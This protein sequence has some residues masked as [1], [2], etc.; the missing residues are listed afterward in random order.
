MMK[1]LLAASLAAALG[2]S[3]MIAD[4]ASHKTKH[5]KTHA[6]SGTTGMSKSGTTGSAG[7]ATSGSGASST[8]GSITP[9]TK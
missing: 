8:G 1:Y 9:G 4:A 7:G 5:H 2:L 3:P 6:M